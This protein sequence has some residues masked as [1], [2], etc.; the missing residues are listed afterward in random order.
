MAVTLQVMVREPPHLAFVEYV[1]PEQKSLLFWWVV[2]ER[3][4]RVQRRE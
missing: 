2:C 4:M 3:V 1:E